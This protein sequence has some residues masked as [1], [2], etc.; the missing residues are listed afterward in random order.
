MTHRFDALGLNRLASLA[1]LTLKWIDCTGGAGGN[2][3]ALSILT[4]L[5]AL[6]LFDDY[7]FSARPESK[8]WNNVRAFSED[9]L[10]RLSLE[11]SVCRMLY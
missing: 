9:R 6:T 7:T 10:V 1:S 3:S 5:T 11:L 2:M 4:R 8:L